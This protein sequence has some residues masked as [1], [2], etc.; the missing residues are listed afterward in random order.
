MGTKEP[1]VE[2]TALL[3]SSKFLTTLF[4]DFHSVAHLW[5]EREARSGTFI[6]E[7]Q[8]IAN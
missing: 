2:L 6:A 3:S 8:S 4:N 5:I 1:V 7:Q